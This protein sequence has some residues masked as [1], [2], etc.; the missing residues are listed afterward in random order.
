MYR[1]RDKFIGIEP[2]SAIFY[3]FKRLKKKCKKKA[4]CD[5]VE[6]SRNNTSQE[7]LFASKNLHPKTQI[8]EGVY[9]M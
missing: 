6:L 5:R 1:R 2:F 9:S 4:L 8:R 3:V 7:A